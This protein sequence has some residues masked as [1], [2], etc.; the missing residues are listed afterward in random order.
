[1]PEYETVTHGG[2]V[3]AQSAGVL[4]QLGPDVTAEMLRAWVRRGRVRRVWDGRCYWYDLVQA[5]EAER[6][7]A[8]SGRGRRRRGATLSTQRAL[9]E[10]AQDQPVGCLS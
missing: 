7:T 2:V 10:A 6:D 1:M 4:A 8:E 5:A 3:Y 9:A